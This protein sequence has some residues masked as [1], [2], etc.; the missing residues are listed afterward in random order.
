MRLILACAC[1]LLGLT[2]VYARMA[3]AE[4]PYVQMLVTASHADY[5]YKTGEQA[6]VTVQAYVG[7]NPLNNA[8]LHYT[9]GPDMRSVDNKDSILFKNGRVEIPVGTSLQPGFRFCHLDFKVG[10]TV[11]RDFLKVAYSPSE[12]QPFT[13]MPSDFERFWRNTLNTASRI[14]LKPEVTFLPKYST[15]SISV[16]LVKLNVDNKGRCLYGYLAKPNAPGKYPVLFTPPGAGSARIEPALYYA[17]QGFISL[18]IEI[19]G[20]NPELPEEEYMKRRKTVADY[21]YRGIADYMTYYYRKVYV[22]CSRSV[23]FLCNLPEFDGK[24]VVVTGGSQ[25][26]A[27]TIITAALN[28]KVTGLAA[29][30]PALSDVT[31]FLHQRAGGWPKFFSSDASNKKLNGI[32]IEV[33]AKT[34]AYYDVVNFARILRVPGFYSFGYCDDTCSPTSVWSV[35]NSITAK[36]KIVITPTSAHWRFPEINQQSIDWLK[37]IGDGEK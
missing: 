10:N 25:G 5:A 32:P 14:P 27:L 18:N 21:F 12:I 35:M 22:G 31:G 1:L 24:H 7:G 30:Y 16:Y 28:P 36:K 23:D 8:Y 6:M 34:L 15:D 33:A 19:H 3:K 17:R 9:T 37:T 11:Y 13:E 29:F 2:E 26:G 20:L 4:R